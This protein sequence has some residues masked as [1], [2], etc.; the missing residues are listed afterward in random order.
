[1]MVNSDSTIRDHLQ[2]GYCC[3]G[4][5]FLHQLL[6]VCPV[7]E[8][9]STI[10]K[11]IPQRK[12][13]AVE[14]NV[15]KGLQGATI[16][17]CQLTTGGIMTHRGQS[18][19]IVPPFG[20]TNVYGGNGENPLP[21]S[22]VKVFEFDA[23]ELVYGN[24]QITSAIGIGGAGLM[25]WKDKQWNTFLNQKNLRS[26][27]YF[28]KEIAEAIENSITKSEG[29][30][31]FWQRP[32]VDVYLGWLSYYLFA[33]VKNSLVEG[34]QLPNAKDGVLQFNVRTRFAD[35]HKFIDLGHS[36]L[37]K[38]PTGEDLWALVK[39]LASAGWGQHFPLPGCVLE[40]FPVGP[41]TMERIDEFG[42]KS[43][44]PPT[45]YEIILA[46][47]E[48]DL[49]HK[50]DIGL[51]K[52]GMQH[53][54]SNPAIIIEFR[55]PLSPCP[56]VNGVTVQTSAAYWREYLLRY[57]EYFKDWNKYIEGMTSTAPAMDYSECT[58]YTDF[59][60]DKEESQCTGVCNGPFDLQRKNCKCFVGDEEQP[61]VPDETSELSDYV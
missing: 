25:M 31:S 19:P 52:M 17:S 20:Y 30:T 40:D 43:K 5:A 53:V 8:R 29:S 48:S 55:L 57:F 59:E 61:P 3:M 41:P 38:L 15:M 21:W 33:M 50:A 34:C 58:P 18:F 7:A 26:P 51:G 1:M 10:D 16:C 14:R 56:A 2:A 35:I 24:I 45:M 6:R 47:P 22:D 54:D 37:E 28:P 32:H 27:M 44:S 4:N 42:V 9:A 36:D 23:A 13:I 46:L 39:H 60:F 11:L 12:N 49:F